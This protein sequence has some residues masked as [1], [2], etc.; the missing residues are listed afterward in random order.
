[1]ENTLANEAPDSRRPTDAGWSTKR[2]S[3]APGVPLVTVCGSPLAIH[4]T[5]VPSATVRLDPPP[6]ATYS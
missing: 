5:S 3:I 1:M 2:L 4:V 6:G